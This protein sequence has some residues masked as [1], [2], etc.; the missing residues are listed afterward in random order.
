M[1][2][3]NIIDN[4]LTIVPIRATAHL[5]KP[6]KAYPIVDW[7]VVIISGKGNHNDQAWWVFDARTMRNAGDCSVWTIVNDEEIYDSYESTVKTGKFKGTVK[8]RDVRKLI[9][10]VLAR[11]AVEALVLPV[12]E[13]R[14]PHNKRTCN[15]GCINFV[16]LE[17]EGKSTTMSR[18]EGPEDPCMYCKAKECLLDEQEVEH[19]NKARMKDSG[20]LMDPYGRSH[21]TVGFA[22]PKV[23]RQ[24]HSIDPDN[25]RRS[26]QEQEKEEMSEALREENMKVIN[27]YLSDG[28]SIHVENPEFMADQFGCYGHIDMV[29]DDHVIIDR[30]LSK[31]GDVEE[32]KQQ[33]LEALYENVENDYQAK[34]KAYDEWLNREVMKTIRSI[35]ESAHPELNAPKVETH[36]ELVVADAP[37]TMQELRKSLAWSEGLNCPYFGYYSFSKPKKDGTGWW[38]PRWSIEPG[39]VRVADRTSYFVQDTNKEVVTYF[40]AIAGDVEVIWDRQLV[41]LQSEMPNRTLVKLGK[42]Q[43]YGV[44]LNTL[45][46]AGIKIE[47]V[48][49]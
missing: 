36:V 24:F 32:L 41:E 38:D 25:V 1:T 18:E 46:R 44:A 48:L 27:G 39:H 35:D 16:Q 28:Q 29:E 14:Y 20:E 37:V 17:V 21:T 10:I 8:Y 3:E 6:W 23:M 40:R 7:T 9:G 15:K 43:T 49:K 19:Y 47:E 42:K 4:K 5:E 2:M 33:A 30:I 31:E 34:N 13:I 45:R 26:M 12:T 22:G 11:A